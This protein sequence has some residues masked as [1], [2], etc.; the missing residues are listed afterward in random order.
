[1]TFH[2]SHHQRRFLLPMS[3]ICAACV[4]L[5]LPAVAQDNAEGTGDP[6]VIVSPFETVDIAVQDADLAQV[7]QMLSLQSRK[8]IITSRNVSATVTA[9]L[10]DVTFYEALDAI[11]KVNGYTY[12]EEGNFIYVYTLEEFEQIQAAQLQREYRVFDVEH[13][14]AAD[15]LG[16]ITPL[17]SDG[18]SAEA[19]GDVNPGMQPDVSD[20]GA[21]DY[22]FN[23]KVVAFDYP[24]NLERIATLIDELDVAPDQVLV[25][26]TIVQASVNEANAF[27]ID[28]SIVANMNFADIIAPLN[29]VTALLNGSGENGFAPDDNDAQGIQST[30]GNTSGP[31]GFKV[32]IVTDDISIFLRALDEVTDTVVLARPKIMALNRQRAEVLVGARVG[33]LS[34]TATETTT[35]QTVEFLDTGIQLVFRPFISK[36]GTIRMELRPSVS[37]AS[38]RTVTDSLGVQVTIPD[39]LTNELT[40]NVRVRDGQTLVLGGLFRESTT[41]NRRQVPLLGDIPILGYAFRGQDDR[42]ERNEIIFLITPTI[43]KDEV[44]WDNGE[45][46]MAMAELVRIGAREG[47]L[48]WSREKMTDSHNQHAIAAMKAGD[49]DLALYHVRN[50]LRL[51]PH[52]PNVIAMR[53]QLTGDVDHAYERSALERVINRGIERTYSIDAVR[54]SMGSDQAIQKAFD[55]NPILQVQAISPTPDD[56][57]ESHAAPSTEPAFENNVASENAA[58]ASN[59]P[60]DGSATHEFIPIETITDDEIEATFGIEMSNDEHPSNDSPEIESAEGWKWNGSADSGDSAFQ[61]D[62]ESA[63]VMSETDFGF[64]NSVNAW[65]GWWFGIPVWNQETNTVS[66]DEDRAE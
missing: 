54:H 42:V 20:N 45:E 12:N 31:G 17:L 51:N 29:P 59:A 22:A 6:S 46:M 26:S 24:E 11:L 44:L 55:R 28:F 3:S 27:G 56:I 50:S 5:G 65:T 19:R 38:L 63:D 49:T 37:E 36:D 64:R 40:T 9:N 1:M 35:T 33:Y 23:V 47:L 30:V 25:E 60:F 10:Y 62:S 43:T 7:L 48:F 18:G 41:T 34:T 61:F 13:L 16:F 32:G 58:A 39:E 57:E 8:N 4:G 53:Q 14:A 21:D 66:V 2:N 15:I 52:Q